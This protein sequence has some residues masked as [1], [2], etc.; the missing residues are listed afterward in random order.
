MNL[1]IKEKDIQITQRNHWTAESPVW[2]PIRKVFF[3]TDIEGGRLHKFDPQNHTTNTWQ[4]GSKGDGDKNGQM[5]G[6]VA[7]NSD[8]SLIILLEA[9]ENAGI[10]YFNPDKDLLLNIPNSWPEKDKIYNRPNDT[11]VVQIGGKNMMIYGTM[12]KKWSESKNYD[13][14]FYV[15]D[16]N[17]KSHK[18]RF[19][20]NIYPGTIISNGLAD[21]G[22]ND[23]GTTKLFWVESVGPHDSRNIYTGNLNP[24]TYEVKNVKIFADYSEI[25][26]GT[27]AFPDGAN[28][29]NVRGKEAYAVSVLQLGE[30]RAFDPNTGKK[31]ASI[32]L[33]EGLANN[34]KFAIGEDT[35]GKN[36]LFVTTIN[37]DYPKEKEGLNGCTALISLPEEI[38]MHTASIKATDY[39]SMESASTK[40]FEESK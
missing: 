3:Y 17:L 1:V 35:E 33:P 4:I 18:I 11:T 28:M 16:E 8:G 19:E 39:I 34:T 24:I 30:I 21:G 10:N 9:A 7:L 20:G 6:G 38:T 15:L 23:D 26:E 27:E 14:A 12:S 32:K 5:V 36:I 13:G 22:M 31:V 29:L 2:D 37:F 40:F 25:T